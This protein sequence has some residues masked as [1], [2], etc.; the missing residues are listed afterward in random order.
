VKFKSLVWLALLLATSVFAQKIY[1]QKDI[2]WIKDKWVQKENNAT[3]NGLFVEYSKIGE[4][5]IEVPIVKGKRS[6]I[7]KEYYSKGKIFTTSHYQNDMRNGQ[8]KVYDQGG[9]LDN[10]AH[11]VD[12]LKDGLEICYN[13]EGVIT[14]ESHYKQGKQDG[15]TKLYYD[16]GALH[17]EIN[18]VNDEMNGTR[19]YYYRSGSLSLEEFSDENG[20]IGSKNYYESGEL[21]SE[22]NVTKG[23]VAGFSRLYDKSGAL[24]KENIYKIKY[25][26]AH[27]FN[28]VMLG[29]LPFFLF[30]LYK[31]GKK[32]APLLIGYILRV[33]LPLLFAPTIGVVIGLMASS[34]VS[35]FEGGAMI[36][37]Q[38]FFYYSSILSFFIL[39]FITNKKVYIAL[40]VVSILVWIY[41]QKL[42]VWLF[43]NYYF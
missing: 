25:N 35:S 30:W 19:K 21:Q 10:E 17:Q 6:G 36:S 37:F 9:R 39:L 33:G 12:D 26:Y 7:R 15:I 22:I 23:T 3:V 28:L 2:V 16:S 5:K 42:P 20:R 38:M 41:F 32:S 14:D 27:I 40:A 4:I 18:Y 43:Y 31:K 13:A 29:L 34:G 1:E 11:Y 8:H 24:I